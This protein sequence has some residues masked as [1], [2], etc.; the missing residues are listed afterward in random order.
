MGGGGGGQLKIMSAHAQSQAMPDVPYTAGVQ[1]LLKG[2][3]SSR[4]F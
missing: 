3:G 2:P 1:G 4:G